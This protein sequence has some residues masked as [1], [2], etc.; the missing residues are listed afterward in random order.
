MKTNEFNAPFSE[1]WIFKD[2]PSITFQIENPNDVAVTAHIMMMLSSDLKFT[3]ETVEQDAEIPAKSTQSIVVTTSG[4][5]DP[6]FYRARCFVNKRTDKEMHFYPEMQHAYPPNWNS[7][8][9]KFFK[10]RIK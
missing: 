2:K 3:G 4:K 6:G 1:N 9:M 8:I 7:D 10:A 5:L